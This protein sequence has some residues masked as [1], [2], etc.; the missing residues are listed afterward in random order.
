MRSSSSASSNASSD[1]VSLEVSSHSR[2]KS[3]LVEGK[4]TSDGLTMA[5]R[6]KLEKKAEEQKNEEPYSFLADHRD[7]GCSVNTN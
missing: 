6:R 5:E 2:N 1:D 3:R 4:K 7:V